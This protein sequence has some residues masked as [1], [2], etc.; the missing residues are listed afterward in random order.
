MNQE[1]LTTREVSK[2][3]KINEKL[4]YRLI[5]DGGIPCTRVTGKWLFPKTLID[6]WMLVSVQEHRR[7]QGPGGTSQDRI[8]FVGSD[9]LLLPHLARDLY[10]TTPRVLFLWSPLGSLA[11]LKSLREGQGEIAG[12]HLLDPK[13]GEYN[14]SFLTSQF[15]DM[16][17][18]LVRMA[19]RQQGLMVQPG[20]PLGVRSVADLAGYSLRIINRQPGSGTRTL[21]DHLLAET[22]I[23]SRRLPGYEREVNTHGEV[24]QSVLHGEADTG[25]GTYSAARASGLE[26]IPLATERYDLVIRKEV[27]GEDRFQKLLDT[28]RSSQLAGEALRLGGYD[29]REA[30]ELIYL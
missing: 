2:Y 9:D 17:L 4:V 29:V 20:N 11:G 19:R 28:L 1:Y 13:T 10:S 30:G 8:L 7:R 18:V 14:L 5:Q 25:L 22:A 23:E 12:I 27:L 24:A 15:P 3:L 21:L 26:F 6:D 16:N